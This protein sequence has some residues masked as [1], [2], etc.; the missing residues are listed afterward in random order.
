MPSQLGQQVV[1]GR[2]RHRWFRPLPAREREATVAGA[3]LRLI[4]GLA[5]GGLFFLLGA[6]TLA[7]VVWGVG[8]TLGAVSIA[9]ATARRRL[10]GFFRRLG[11]WLGRLLALLLL[12]PFLLVLGVARGCLWVAGR[13]PLR[14]K[15]GV[16]RS[17][18]RECDDME[19]KDRHAARM[20][21]T[22]RRARR[23]GL[24]YLVTAL[25]VAAVV[26]EV[27]LRLL[28]FG[29]PLLHEP[30]AVVGYY[31]APSLQ[32]RRCGTT[33][34]TNAFGQRAPDYTRHKPAGVFRVLVLGGSALWGGT[35]LGDEHLFARR[36]E[37][38]LGG[39]GREVQVLN[40]A[41]E[42]WGPKHKL[43]YL[44][45]F[46][47]FDADVAVVVVAGDDLP[48]PAGAPVGVPLFLSHR[49]P[50]L[51]LTALFA[52]V[53]GRLAP[54][55][56][57]PPPPAMA[58]ELAQRGQAAY[59]E[60][61]RRLE[62]EGAEVLVALLPAAGSAQGLG[63][64]ELRAALEA[65]GYDAM[66]PDLQGGE[67]PYSR[68]GFLSRIGHELLADHLTLRLEEAGGRLARWR[69]ELQAPRER[70]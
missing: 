32:V 60:L 64:G 13:D 52:G 3:A 20:F 57:S 43:G 4:I 50:R 67:P 1:H 12:G 65:E 56:L 14:L 53:L 29:T 21:A 70:P 68:G 54:G 61:S 27:L 38:R 62:R 46:G 31:P 30:D 35:R 17:F 24:G 66:T 10:G 49:P 37:A 25:L 19:R 34:R 69:D 51:A 8:G 48:R 59:L 6:R 22:E 18:W 9:S 15:R 2:V 36:M 55:T 41:A 47:S 40:A 5:V 45:R 23:R 58:A 26:G 44:A 42:G 28:G 33:L 39:P 63:V 16:E 7:V 11:E